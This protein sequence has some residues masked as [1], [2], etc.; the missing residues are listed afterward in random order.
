M[1]GPDLTEVRKK[2][3]RAAL[4]ENIVEPSKG[5]APEFVLHSVETK[6]GEGRVGFVVA[7]DDQGLRL[8]VE[9]GEVVT[10]PRSQVVA[11][12]PAALSAMPEGLL[13]DLTAQE[14]ADLLAYLSAP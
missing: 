7:S 10:L 12:D 8:R 11:D 5:I 2:F 4:L 13:A 3:D 9:S 1:Y 6:D 14:V